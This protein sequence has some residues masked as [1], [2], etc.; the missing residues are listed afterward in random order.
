MSLATTRESLVVVNDM[1]NAKLSLA[2]CLDQLV[3]A[4]SQHLITALLTTQQ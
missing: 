1:R 3:T 2:V 4:I